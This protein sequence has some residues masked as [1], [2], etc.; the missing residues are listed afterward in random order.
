MKIK[1]LTLNLHTY[2]ELDISKFETSQAFLDAYRIIQKHIAKFIVQNDVDF[3]T[4]QEAGQ[5][6]G[7]NGCEKKFGIGIKPSNYLRLLNNILSEYGGKYEYVWDFSHYG[8][9]IWE[10]GLGILSKHRIVD[11]ESRYV[12]KET[13]PKVFRSRKIIRTGVEVDNK[14]FDVYSVHFN[15]PELGFR[16]ELENVL[17]W[18]EKRG[19][20]NFIVAG[21]FNVS[22]NSQEYGLIKDARVFD[23]PLIDAWINTNPSKPSEPTFSGDSSEPPSRIDYILLPHSFKPLR[24]EVVFKER[25]GELRVSDHFGL[26][27]EFEID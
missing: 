23:K 10:E 9:N 4:F 5:L 7:E 27:C 19:N 8:F 25:I 20:E 13:D 21:D 15:W 17:K 18:I 2:Q 1:V 26:L 11:F 22:S 12:S 16:E 3:V 24:S 14:I 6:Q